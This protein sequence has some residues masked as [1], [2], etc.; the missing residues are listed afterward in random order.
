MPPPL[1]MLGIALLATAASSGA[2]RSEPFQTLEQCRAL[3]RQQPRSLDGYECLL[4]HRLGHE[5][6]VLRFLERRVRSSP[7]DPRPR[8]YRAIVH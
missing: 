7:G 4:A 2:A 6:D 5:D 8:L 3:V 1:R